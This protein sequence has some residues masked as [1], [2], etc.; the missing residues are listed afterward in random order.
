MNRTRARHVWIRG[1]TALAAAIAITASTALSAQ[2]SPAPGKVDMRLAGAIGDCSPNWVHIFYK[3][4]QPVNNW[5]IRITGTDLTKLIGAPVGHA[6]ILIRDSD[7]EESTQKPFDRHNPLNTYA[8]INGTH[9]R[10]S[11]NVA[12]KPNNGRGCNS[13]FDIAHS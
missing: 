7:G 2:A 9:A 8:Y 4:K 3:Q 6:N 12:A 11:V 10:I 1:V 13:V 5:L